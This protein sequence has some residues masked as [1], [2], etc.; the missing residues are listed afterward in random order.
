VAVSPVALWETKLWEEHKFA[1]LCD[2]IVG[3]LGLKVVLTGDKAGGVLSRIEARM[4]EAAVN[5]GGKTTLRD[6]AALYKRAELLVTTDSGP[7][8]VAAAVGTAVVAL[9]GP[10]APWRTGPYAR[11][12]SSSGKRRPAAPAF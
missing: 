3:E 12:M 9:F 4:T 5:L 1:A 8:H 6:L 2:R 7:M 10:T 11:A